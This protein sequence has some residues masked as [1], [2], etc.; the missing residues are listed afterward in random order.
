M[1]NGLVFITC[2]TALSVFGL[3]GCAASNSEKSVDGKES[4]CTASGSFFELVGTGGNAALEKC[5]TQ[6]ATDCSAQNKQLRVISE[7]AKDT[8][9]FSLAEANLA[10]S[11]F[12]QN[13]LV[14]EQ[15]A[16]MEAD[17]AVFA[18][19]VAIAKNRCEKQLG[20]SPDTPEMRNCVLTVQ[21]QIANQQSTE[22][23]RDKIDSSMADMAAQNAQHAENQRA[24]SNAAVINDAIN[25]SLAPKPSV[26][27][28]TNNNM[29]T[30]H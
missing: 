5:R 29:T 1:N 10:Y 24:A 7:S 26:T 11:C 22:K 18:E 12:D 9:T 3:T 6:A 20:F 17:D 13:D 19:T 14:A 4:L 23:L 25:K 21:Q 28:I 2:I 8:T 27:C 16:K 15:K 30:C